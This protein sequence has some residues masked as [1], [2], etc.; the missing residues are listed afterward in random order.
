[1]NRIRLALA[2]PVATTCLGAVVRE[3]A[4]DG[5]MQASG[6]IGDFGGMA[7]QVIVVDDEQ[8]PD[9][10]ADKARELVERSGADIVVGPIFSNI[11][12]AIVQRVTQG[13]AILISPNAGS[14]NLAGA[15]PFSRPP[16][17]MTRCTR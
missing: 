17:R 10:A 6:Q 13:G 14:S 3:M 11:A 1:M 4:R 12:G 9:I 5:F 16:I 15:G 7:T 2:A 8:K